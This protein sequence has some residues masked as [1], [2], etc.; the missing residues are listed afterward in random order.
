MDELGKFELPVMTAVSRLRGNAYGVSV[1]DEV[2]NSQGREVSYGAV[3]VTLDRLVEKGYLT[4]V[5]GDPTP[6]RGGRRKRF[7]E[8]TGKGALALS[9]TRQQYRAR[10]ADIGTIIPEP[11][12]G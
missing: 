3:H 12:G 7:Y 6:Q 11:A 5:M 1:M 8:L 2:S 10:L 9:Y 4:S